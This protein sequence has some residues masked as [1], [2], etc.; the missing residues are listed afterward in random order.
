M[1]KRLSLL[2][3]VIAISV[4]VALFSTS[5]S[6]L[7]GKSAEKEPVAASDPIC[8]AVLSHLL[9]TYQLLSDAY[10]AN[11]A[12]SVPKEDD[13]RIDSL[14]YAGEAIL[15]ETTYA[16]YELV[17]SMYWFT[18]S[19]AQPEGKYGWHTIDPCFVVLKQIADGQSFNEVIGISYGDE[20]GKRA[21]EI[22]SEVV[23]GLMDIAVSFQFD[24]Y[25]PLVG[26]GASF[27]PLPEI[28]KE[29]ILIDA[30]PIHSDG[31]YWV[32]FSFRELNAICYHDASQSLD[33]IYSID[34]TRTDVQTQKGIRVGQTRA[35]VEKTYPDARNRPFW[36]Y[37]GDYLWWSRNESAMGASIVFWFDDDRVVKI[38]LVHY[39]K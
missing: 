7:P 28:P 13:L 9:F 36:G 38:E 21:D 26:P 29:E 3:P 37:T 31:D 22:I 10:Y 8:D 32:R 39:F 6:K 5:C 17:Y 2:Y 23:Y 34:T 18:S 25:S 4:L 15:Q 33:T 19:D 24:E 11:D 16:A 30:E 35:Q 20:T 14:T 1:V 27:I 12:P